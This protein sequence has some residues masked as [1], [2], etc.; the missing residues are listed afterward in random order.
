MRLIVDIGNSNVT[1][2]LWKAPEW[3]Y[4][5]RLP[6]RADQSAL[7]FY[8]VQLSNLFLEAR[9]PEGEIRQVV[10][11]SV[12][13]DLRD[14]WIAVSRTLTGLDPVLV[15]PKVFPFLGMGIQKPDEI[16]TDLVANAFAA[17]QLYRKDC[18][19]VDFGTALTFTTL[20][21]E[22]DILGVSIAPGLKT[23]IKSLFLNT[24]QLPEV[25]LVLPASAVGK[26]TV[27][28]IQSGILIGYVGLVKHMLEVIR[29]ELGRHY[30]A[31]ATG[32]LSSIL[33]PLEGMFEVIDPNLTL[34][35]LRLIGEKFY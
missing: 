2:G 33:H 25:P 35:G 11:S 20:T 1:I 16:G 32:G 5:W 10:I 30:I 24:A 13:P 22:G 15:G 12:V 19:V 6:T 27:H 7:M 17:F 3:L 31:V 18:V 34:T 4:V 14:T 9:L 21:G 28:A 29:A 8:E 26:D 23:A